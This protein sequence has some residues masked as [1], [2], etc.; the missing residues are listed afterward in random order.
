MINIKSN[1][2]ITLVALISTVIILLILAG[3]TITKMNTTNGIGSYNNMVADI[4]L[5]KDKIHVYY[6]KYDE[7]PT[8]QRNISINNTL[9]YEIDLQKLDNI[10]LNYGQDYGKLEELTTSSDVYL[11]NTNL[12]IYY[13]KGINKDQQT[14]H[15][16]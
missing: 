12:N 11:I 8:T 13:L 4:K 2:G 5:L 7:I 14:Y 6:N 1:K 9:Y 16:Q 10:T 3:V 15:V